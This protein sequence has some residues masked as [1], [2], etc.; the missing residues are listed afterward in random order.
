MKLLGGLKTFK[1]TDLAQGTT[2]EAW[3]KKYDQTI[4]HS[5]KPDQIIGFYSGFQGAGCKNNI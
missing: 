3:Q 4:S 1:A 2:E 5:H